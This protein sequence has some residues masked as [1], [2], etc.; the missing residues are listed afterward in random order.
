M[1]KKNVAFSEELNMQN[2]RLL[3]LHSSCNLDFISATFPQL[4]AQISKKQNKPCKKA[5][6]NRAHM[7]LSD[8]QSQQKKLGI[9]RVT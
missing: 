3:P 2:Q 8:I 5:H 1:W 9:S 6:L 4:A 7:P